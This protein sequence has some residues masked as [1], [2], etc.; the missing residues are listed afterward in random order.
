MDG[1]DHSIDDEEE[2]AAQAGGQE[3]VAQAGGQ[4]GV[5][6]AEEP[7][8]VDSERGYQ[9]LLAKQEARIKELEGQVAEAAKSAEVAD[10]LRDEIQ[11][12]KARRPMSASP[13][14]QT[15][16]RSQP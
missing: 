14:R 11:Q 1:D 6:Q 13:S 8:A 12:V 9:A 4:E 3:G 2:V 15:W 7:Q 10:A 16:R 5:A